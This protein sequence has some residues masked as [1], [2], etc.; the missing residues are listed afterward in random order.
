MK[1]DIAFTIY[2]V[3][4]SGPLSVNKRPVKVKWAR[5]TKAGIFN[6]QGALE[7]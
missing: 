7:N 4:E 1:S 2:W 3:G 6:P 5:C